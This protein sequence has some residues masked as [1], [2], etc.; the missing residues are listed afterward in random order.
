MLDVEYSSPVGACPAPI[1]SRE[2]GDGK[3]NGLPVSEVEA[4]V[5][6]SRYA[7]SG[8]RSLTPVVG[9]TANSREV[10]QQVKW[11]LASR[12]PL[13]GRCIVIDLPIPTNRHGSSTLVAS[14]REHHRDLPMNV[15][16]RMNVVAVDARSPNCQ[17]NLCSMNSRAVPLGSGYSGVACWFHAKKRSAR[18]VRSVSGARILPASERCSFRSLLPL[19]L[20]RS[21]F[22]AGVRQ[23]A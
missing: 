2:G 13:E 10:R 21:P 4:D 18:V 17:V 9:R 6:L 15:D 5:A 23:S 3:R 19:P 14:M 22:H 12:T 16:C 20:V 7:P 8:P 1:L 11:T